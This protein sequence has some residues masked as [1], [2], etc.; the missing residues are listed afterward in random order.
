M[1]SDMSKNIIALLGNDD[2]DDDERTSKLIGQT[3]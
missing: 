2:D 1:H 3:G